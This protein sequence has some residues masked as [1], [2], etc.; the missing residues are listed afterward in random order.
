MHRV[1][2]FAL[3]RRADLVENDRRENAAPMRRIDG[4]DNARLG[5]I[6]RLNEQLALRL[7]D[8]G[9]EQCRAIARLAVA[10]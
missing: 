5:E 4:R 8:L 3:L 9:D 6:V 1:S 10:N 7:R 2:A